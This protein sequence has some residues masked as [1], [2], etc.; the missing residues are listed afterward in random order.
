MLLSFSLVGA[1]TLQAAQ[2]Q[3]PPRDP[4]RGNGPEEVHRAHLKPTRQ[5]PAE[6][7]PFVMMGQRPRLNPH[8][9][10]ILI[11]TPSTNA[12]T[13]APVPDARP[14][15]PPVSVRGIVESASGNMAIL[16]LPGSNQVVRTGDQLGDYRV[17]AI[18]HGQVSLTFKDSTFRLPLAK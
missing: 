4:F 5:L 7:D 6:R 12:L 11:P 17:S 16:R 10:I 13:P 8:P 2:A 1:V 18:G 9:P 15:A 14:V 3:S